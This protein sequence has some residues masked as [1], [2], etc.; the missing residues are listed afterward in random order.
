MQTV[1][2]DYTKQIDDMNVKLDE[3]LN[4]CLEIQEQLDE[5]EFNGL[6]T[7]ADTD[8]FITSLDKA[9]RLDLLSQL[10]NRVIVWLKGNFAKAKKKAKKKT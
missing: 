7:Y 9:Q 1:A 8:E 6:W 4:L 2:N 3:L 5:D 10:Q